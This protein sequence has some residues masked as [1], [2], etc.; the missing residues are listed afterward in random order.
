MLAVAAALAFCLPAGADQRAPALDGLFAT[1]QAPQT[2]PGRAQ[3]VTTEIWHHWLEATD[4]DA[5][6]LM[7]LGITRMNE[8]A[9]DQAV[10][11]FTTLIDMSPD[12]AEAW[13]KRAT[14][15]YMIGEYDLSTADVK[16]TLR[17]EPRHFGALSGQGLI[18][19]QQ[20]RKAEALHWFRRALDVNP[21][22]DGVR[23]NVEMLEAEL[24]GTVT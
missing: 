2:S 15:Y 1:L 16:E 13:N 11:I 9:L 6:R 14:V 12:Y 7:N 10:E 21:F 19:M 22:M 17:L 18:Y 5:Q 3:Q 20:D 24:E 8:F 4:E 23:Q